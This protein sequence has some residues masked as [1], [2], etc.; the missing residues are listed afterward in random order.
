MSRVTPKVLIIGDDTIKNAIP[1]VSEKESILICFKTKMSL[2]F[3]KKKVR[4]E[5]N[6]NV[7]CS[8]F[9]FEIQD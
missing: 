2:N 5:W 8:Y 6:C 3:L 7:I 4:M 1:K 9:K